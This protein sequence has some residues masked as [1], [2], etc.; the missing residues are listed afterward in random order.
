MTVPRHINARAVAASKP[1]A[2]QSFA[3]PTLVR[4][5]LL[6]TDHWSPLAA[7]GMTGQR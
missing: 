4:A 5:Q 7:R 6:A 3:S 1:V 2:V